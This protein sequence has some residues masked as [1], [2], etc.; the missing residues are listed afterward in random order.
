MFST[1]YSSTFNPPLSISYQF[2]TTYDGLPF[3]LPSDLDFS[4]E[5]VLISLNASSNTSSNG[6]DDISAHCLFNCRHVIAFPL[7]LLFRRSLSE[8]VF[9]VVWKIC[10]VTPVYKSGDP[11]DIKNYRSISIIPHIAKIFESLVF[12]RDKRS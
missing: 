5:D 9:P 12:N 4:Q 7:F 6:P 8:G 1:N 3:E 11:S 10:S 2:A